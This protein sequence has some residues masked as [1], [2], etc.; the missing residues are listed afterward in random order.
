MRVSVKVVGNPGRDAV[1][2]AAAYDSAGRMLAWGGDFQDVAEPDT[3][4]ANIYTNGAD[5]VTVFLFRRADGQPISAK[6]VA[7]V[8]N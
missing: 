3:Y 4:R 5:H 6:A 8:V 7:S 2:A 1:L